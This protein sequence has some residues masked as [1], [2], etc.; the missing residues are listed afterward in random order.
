MRFLGEPESFCRIELLA[1]Q[2]NHEKLCMEVNSCAKE[3]SVPEGTLW[4]TLSIGTWLS[5]PTGL[6]SNGFPTRSIR[7]TIVMALTTRFL[8]LKRSSFPLHAGGGDSF[9]G[10]VRRLSGRPAEFLIWSWGLVRV[11]TMRAWEGSNGL[12][13]PGLSRPGEPGG[14]RGGPG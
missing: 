6:V 7:M 3:R 1:Y 4:K 9:T 2:S 5:W 14:L 10:S 11:L 13:P 12:G 8:G